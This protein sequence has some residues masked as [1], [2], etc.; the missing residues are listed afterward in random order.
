MQGVIE[1]SEAIRELHKVKPVVTYTDGM[2]A[3]AS[4]WVGS[5]ATSVVASASSRVGSIGVYVPVVDYSEQYAKE[6]IEVDVIHNKEGV[7]KGAGLE[8]TSLSEIQKEQIQAEVDEI[9]GEFKN[10]VLAVRNV[11]SDAMQG[12]AFMG[13]SAKE[14]GLIDAIGSYQDALYLLDQEIKNRRES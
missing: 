11:P 1:A 7:H 13:K 5:Q 14:K 4:Y 2:M 10:A 3:S 12:Q 6:G 8:G 9:Y